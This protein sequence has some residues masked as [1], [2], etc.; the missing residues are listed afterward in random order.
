[1]QKVIVAPSKSFGG[2]RARMR[3]VAAAELAKRTKLSDRQLKRI[4][5]GYDSVSAATA[6]I[7]RYF[8]LYNT[9][10]PRSSLT[11]RTPDEAY[12]FPLP[13]AAAA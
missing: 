4:R 12:F 5:N 13:L 7:G 2:L 8:T 9:R 6:G 10:C 1:V 3:D 11:D